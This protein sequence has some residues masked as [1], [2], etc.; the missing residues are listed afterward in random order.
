MSSA[1]CG[2]GAS[3]TTYLYTRSTEEPQSA[4]DGYDVAVVLCFHVRKECLCHL[5]AGLA[6]GRLW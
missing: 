4:G 1:I 3:G 2:G 6:R 5:G